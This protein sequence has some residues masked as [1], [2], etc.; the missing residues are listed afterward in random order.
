M[1][2]AED[3]A[4]KHVRDPHVVGISRR[5]RNFCRT[6]DASQT[7][8]EKRM[9][10]IWSPSGTG[11]FVDFNLDHCLDAVNHLRDSDLLFLL[12]RRLWLLHSS[13]PG[14]GRVSVCPR[15]FSPL[16]GPLQRPLDKYRNDRS[17]PCMLRELPRVWGWD[18]LSSK[19]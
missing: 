18:S 9:P 19:R 16:P 1:R 4:V 14:D 11:I 17:F 8:I 12:R 7:V 15:H 3:A 5:T 2:A 13:T 6:I 10:V